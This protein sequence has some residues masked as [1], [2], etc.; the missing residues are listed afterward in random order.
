MKR[1]VI[2]ALLALAVAMLVLGGFR[3]QRKKGHMIR[4]G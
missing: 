4:S 2:G 1:I 3:R